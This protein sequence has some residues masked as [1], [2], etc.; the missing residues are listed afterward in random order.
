M[1]IA[2]WIL[3]GAALGWFAYTRLHFNE[4]RS[5][6]VSVLIGVAGG[7]TG[8]YFFAPMAGVVIAGAGDFSMRS[9][10]IALISAAVGLVVAS[11]VHVR[12]GI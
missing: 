2:L 8:G 3:A 10:I 4:G 7:F 1:N 6:R 5:K 12:L 11:E 9:L